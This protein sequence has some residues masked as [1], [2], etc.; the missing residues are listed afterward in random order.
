M[1][2]YWCL[3][4]L[5]PNCVKLYNFGL[6]CKSSNLRSALWRSSAIRHHSFIGVCAFC[7]WM[8]TELNAAKCFFWRWVLIL[9]WYGRATVP[10]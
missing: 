7:V 2:P 10:R 1:S 4:L 8:S 3:K 9:A 6:Y 5:R